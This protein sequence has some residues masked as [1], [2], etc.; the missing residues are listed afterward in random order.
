MAAWQIETREQ[1]VIQANA[2]P[3]PDFAA[4]L[5]TVLVASQRSDVTA[6]RV[7]EEAGAELANLARIVERR[8]ER[9]DLPIAMCGGIFHN[10]ELVRRVFAER[11]RE[12]CPKAEL[13]DGIVDPVQGALAMARKMV[14]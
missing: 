10:C 12:A 4:L 7:L 1:L 9:D 2:S 6:T 5:P 11:V 8:L 13:R 14:P 3:G